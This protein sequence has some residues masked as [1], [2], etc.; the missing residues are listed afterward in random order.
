MERTK[1]PKLASKL[2]DHGHW[3][4]E[5]VKESEGDLA[6]MLMKHSNPVVG[7]SESGYIESTKTRKAPESLVP[8][9]LEP[10][11]THSGYLKQS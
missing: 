2:Q 6:G 10:R 1:K 8:C 11:L 9:M 7:T 4:L 5:V 3:E